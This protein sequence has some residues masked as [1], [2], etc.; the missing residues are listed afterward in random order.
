MLT[1][2][3]IKKVKHQKKLYKMKQ[4]MYCV[5]C[6]ELSK[7]YKYLLTIPLTQLVALDNAMVIDKLCEQ[8]EEIR[9]LLVL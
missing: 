3:L 6:T 4:C 1:W 9:C 8:S 7:V 2:N 5:L